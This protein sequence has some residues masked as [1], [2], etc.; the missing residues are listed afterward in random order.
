[1]P[2]IIFSHE[3]GE[4]HKSGVPYARKLA[5]NGYAAYIFDFRSGIIDGNRSDAIEPE[6]GANIGMSVLTEVSDL[7]AV[8]AAVREWEFADSGRIV[9]M[10]GSQGG[11]VSAMEACY[12]PTNLRQ[13]VII[14]PKSEYNRV[15]YF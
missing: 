10:G 7:E 13:Y 3:L 6:E 2:I 4:S 15:N 9:L 8:M 11:M 14:I 12:A 5:S 1:M